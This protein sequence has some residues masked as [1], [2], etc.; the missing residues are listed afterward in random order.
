MQSVHEILTGIGD[1]SELQALREILR[2]VLPSRSS[3]I[4]ILDDEARQRAVQKRMERRIGQRRGC[5]SACV[6]NQG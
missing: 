5:P 4:A 1:T 6:S 2:P 3:K